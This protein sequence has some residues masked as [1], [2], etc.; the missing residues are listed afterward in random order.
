MVLWL[1]TIIIIIILE[2]V[3][4]ANYWSPPKPTKLENR[5]VGPRNLYLNKASY[6]Y[7]IY[8]KTKNHYT[9]F[10]AKCSQHEDSLV[11]QVTLQNS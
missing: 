2:L 7:F 3:K 8:T 1:Q 4:N 5:G 10:S 6:V 11:T 9:R